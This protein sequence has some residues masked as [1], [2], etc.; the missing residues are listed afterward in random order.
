MTD[1]P[2]TTIHSEI[3][4]CRSLPTIHLGSVPDILQAAEIMASRDHGQGLLGKALPRLSDE[5][6]D[7][8]ENLMVKMVLDIGNLSV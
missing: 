8:D 5:D 2:F 1:I 6:G 4:L 7:L 3:P